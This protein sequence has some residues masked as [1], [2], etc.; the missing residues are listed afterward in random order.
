MKITFSGA[1]GGDCIKMTAEGSSMHDELACPQYR[2]PFGEA[3]HG[4]H[5]S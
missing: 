1:G 5:L 4:S 3:V 2:Q